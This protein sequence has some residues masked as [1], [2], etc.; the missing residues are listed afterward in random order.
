MTDPISDILTRIR[1]AQAVGHAF[2]IVPFSKIKISIVEILAKNNFV[3]NITKKGRG[4][5]KIIEIEL[6]YKDKKNTIPNIHGIKRIS[7]PGKRKYVRA[8]DIKSVL[9][10]KGISIISTPK[11]LMTGAEAKKSN[12]GGELLCE[13]W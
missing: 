13:V 3:G 1:N 5:K 2:V 4:V 6:K 12:L 10:G 8:K 7:K 11:G 9:N